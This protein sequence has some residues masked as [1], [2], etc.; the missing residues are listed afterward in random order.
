MS[1]KNSP[2]LEEDFLVRIV[3]GAIQNSKQA[4]KY[5]FF[6]IQ[7]ELQTAFFL[8]ASELK[9]KIFGKSLGVLT[10]VID[11]VLQAV[12]YYFL[13]AIVFKGVVGASFLSL[14]MTVVL[15]QLFAKPLGNAPSAFGANA[16]IL[17]QTNF[18]LRIVFFSFLS[19]ELFLW[20]INFVILVLFLALNG[21][22]PNLNWVYLPVFIFAQFVFTVALAFPMSILG[23]YI[24]DL[25]TFLAPMI[26]IWF[27][28]SPGIYDKSRIPLQY[29][30]LYDLNPFVT[31]FEAYRA[32]FFKIG[33][34]QFTG[35]GIVF[36]LS[37]VFLI[38]EIKFL[39][40]ALRRIYTYI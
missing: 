8:T 10:L 2:L 20:V 37:V 40:L 29:Q 12:I 35:I 4:Y 30:W 26:G 19:F 33:E 23:A 7:N 14:F 39:K 22:Y 38:L 16:G 36:I 27:Y 31:F 34:V 1:K 3:P 18:S 28:L 11:P 24:K 9:A 32:I 15:W 25:P 13:T 17:K 21:V 5:Y 6:Q